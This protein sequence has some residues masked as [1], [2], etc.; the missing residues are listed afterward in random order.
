MASCLSMKS[1]RPDWWC[2]P[3]ASTRACNGGCQP[4]SAGH[5]FEECIR[6]LAQTFFS[7]RSVTHWCWVSGLFVLNRSCMISTTVI[8][9]NKA[10]F[11]STEMLA[12]L[13]GRQGC[14]FLPPP[15]LKGWK[16]N[17]NVRVW[18]VDPKKFYQ[19]FPPKKIPLTPHTPPNWKKVG[20]FKWES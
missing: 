10:K 13:V 11:R 9:L 5:A 17:V 2:H 4:D 15:H 12:L 16:R 20:V 8:P 14:I 19:T 6:P 3:S 1:S 18:P 7:Q